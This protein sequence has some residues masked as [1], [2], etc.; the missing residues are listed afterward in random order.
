MRAII[1]GGGIGG[2][3][4]AVAL[5]RA[6]IEAIVFEQQADLRRT[7]VGGGIHMWT[8]AM[9]ALQ[10]LELAGRVSELGAPIERTAF[11][12]RGGKA[13]GSWPLAEIAREHG[14]SDVGITRGEL[15]QVLV[16]A[17]DEA[18]VHEAVR[19]VGFTQDESGVTARFADSREERADL[20]VGADGLRSTI[21]AQLLG[22]TPP[23]YA[24]YAQL[25]A[26]ADGG[27]DL[28]PA[29]LER[30]VFGRGQ[31]AVLHHVGGGKLFWAGAL[32]GPEGRFADVGG[33]KE[34]LLEA[35]RGWEHPI[36][37]AIEAT[38]E[39]AIVGFD[40]YDRPPVDRWGTG[41]V[42]LVGDAAH[43][44]TTN[45]SQGGCQALEDA[46]VLASSMREHGDVPT[47]LR[48]FEASRISRTSPLVKQSY[49]IA[50]MGGIR[51]PIGCALRDRLMGLTLGTVALK[52]HRAFLAAAP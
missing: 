13:L 50:R 26:V 7:Q 5:R 15:Q 47:A 51:N 29:G 48:A 39:E 35:F 8:N 33:R 31:R 52:S 30:I 22:E 12:T 40:I 11:A 19:C 3:S 9:R 20:L 41:R 10:Q 32:Y 4:T 27:P 45:L 38:P 43:P 14:T 1:I 42:T 25:Q 37:A 23:R 24:G 28:L 46:V 16:E 18:A 21:R 6:G 2:L 44:M 17:Q 49:R 36:E 34:R